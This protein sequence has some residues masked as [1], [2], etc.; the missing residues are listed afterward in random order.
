MPCHVVGMVTFLL[1]SNKYSSWLLVWFCSSSVRASW[2]LKH[3][4]LMNTMKL[5]YFLMK[6][7]KTGLLYSCLKWTWNRQQKQTNRQN[8]N[9]ETETMKR[10]NRNRK[11]QR[12]AV[13]SLLNSIWSMWFSQLVNSGH[14]IIEKH[15]LHQVRHP[16]TLPSNNS[17]KWSDWFRVSGNNIDIMFVFNCRN[18]VVRMP[19]LRV[20][21]RQC[22]HLSITLHAGS[23]AGSVSGNSE[24]EISPHRYK[25]TFVYR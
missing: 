9:H 25:L 4:T 3:H 2:G 12:R 13:N 24:Q 18:N 21:C 11:E 22:Q 17:S 16:H 6:K 8:R 10:T 14:P 1:H 23:P 19:P 20:H 7:T 5:D 15:S